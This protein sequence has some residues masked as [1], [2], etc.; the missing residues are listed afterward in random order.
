[1]EMFGEVGGTNLDLLGDDLGFTRESTEH[2]HEVRRILIPE[3]GARGVC[4]AR[5]GIWSSEIGG[6]G[7]GGVMHVGGGRRGKSAGGRDRIH[8]LMLRFSRIFRFR[9][10]RRC[11]AAAAAA[12]P[13]KHASKSPVS[14]GAGKGRGSGRAD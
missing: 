13:S 1:M 9:I 14:S 7:S 12:A 6:I 8:T 4:L 10:Q 3:K 11:V 5:L 2:I